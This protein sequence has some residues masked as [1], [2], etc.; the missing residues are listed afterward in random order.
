MKRAFWT[1]ALVLSLST[2]LQAGYVDAVLVDAPIG[3]WR[4]GE[5][6]GASQ[7]ADASGN[8]K[9]LNYN[10]F[11]AGDYGLPGAL[12]GDTAILFNSAKPADTVSSPNTTDFGFA[13]GQSFSVEYWFKGTGGGGDAGILSKGYD[14]APEVRPWYISRFRNDGKGEFYLRSASGANSNPI[15]NTQI[16]D[17]QWHHIVGIYDAQTSQSR[18]YVDGALERVASAA[19][20]NYGVNTRPFILANHN[21]RTL[22]ATL[23]EVAIYNKAL[24]NVDAAGGI[25]GR[26][27]VLAHYLAAAGGVRDGLSVDFSSSNN[28]GS[29]TAGTQDGFMPFDA[30]EPGGAVTRIF[31]SL[32][33]IGGEIAVTIEGYTHFRDYGTIT[34]PLTGMN[35][36]LADSVLR[37]ATGTMRLTLG[38]L[39][40]GL[41]DLTTY[42]HSSYNSNR[43]P[44]D[45][46]LHDA[47]GERLIF[48]GALTS[49]GT[50]PA[51]FSFLD[52][53][54][55]SDGTNPVWLEFTGG[56]VAAQMALNGFELN[57]PEPAT[58]GLLALASGALG[59]YIRRRRK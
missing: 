57:V 28:S 45:V 17:G 29:G 8:N 52:F 40:A 30:T 55:V 36:L 26:N 6:A 37:N 59:G 41:Y 22:N 15:G 43:T 51:D 7:A 42:H 25:D 5:A 4:L 50:A 10:G 16:N 3:Y 46:R 9:P 58:L 11:A 23:D 1:V 48:Q 20:D 44:F 13:S 56:D 49:A 14:T 12:A 54:V 27:R 2:A 34:G 35:D 19:A 32:A 53:S 24:D 33:G 31:P 38:G 39:E 47:L 18:V 21:N